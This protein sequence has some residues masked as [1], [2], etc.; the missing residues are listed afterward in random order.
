MG[1]EERVKRGEGRT[2]NKERG[3][4][5][6]EVKGGGGGGGEKREGEEVE[7]RE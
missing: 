5:R 1:E 4:W 2:G 7:D 3:R 6:E